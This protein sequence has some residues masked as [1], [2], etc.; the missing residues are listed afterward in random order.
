[1]AHPFLVSSQTP[2]WTRRNRHYKG[3]MMKIGLLSFAIACAVAA[4]GFADVVGDSNGDGGSIPDNS[5]AGYVSTVTITDAE[6]IQ[7]ASFSIQGLQHSWIG[8]LIITVD[9]TTSG[10]S[11]VLMH[12]VGTTSNPNSVGDSS[13]MN[14][15]YTFQDGNPSIW[16]EAA[17]GDTNY[18][19]NP[20]VYD[21]SGAKR[22]SCQPEFDLWW[23]ND[24]R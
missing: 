16:S 5:P 4:T 20:G 19:V 18:V 8:D 17:N 9:H 7:D 21:A 11:A 3:N 1:M 24:L 14:G 13:D 2:S 15:T 10:K 22:S 23:R 12:R 6:I